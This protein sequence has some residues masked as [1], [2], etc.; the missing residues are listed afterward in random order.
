MIDGT[1]RLV[2]QDYVFHKS[3]H[4]SGT[5]TRRWRCSA[6][7]KGCKALV[8]LDMEEKVIKK[9]QGIHNHLPPVFKKT[10]FGFILVREKNMR[11]NKV[12]IQTS[13]EK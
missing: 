8:M 11:L 1:K 10:K 9:Y 4:G 12:E 5:K 13:V 3:Y 2:M 6:R 7:Q